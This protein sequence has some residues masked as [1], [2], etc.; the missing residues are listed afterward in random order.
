MRTVYEISVE[1]DEYILLLICFMSAFLLLLWWQKTEAA[2]DLFH[3]C[4]TASS[5]V[6]EDR[7]PCLSLDWQWADGCGRIFAGFGDGAVHA[8]ISIQNPFCCG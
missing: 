1:S 5:L 7:S 3:E 8:W 2:I 6:A 4:L